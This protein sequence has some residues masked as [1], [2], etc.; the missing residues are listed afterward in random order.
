MLLSPHAF[1]I[2]I[3]RTIK[4][5]YVAPTIVRHLL[6]AT[7]RPVSETKHIPAWIRSGSPHLYHDK[8][9]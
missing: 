7:K 9:W 2:A 5:L 6:T 1:R 3:G 4:T 8:L